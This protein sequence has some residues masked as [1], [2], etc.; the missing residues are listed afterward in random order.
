MT[1]RRS[2]E[3]RIERKK[4]SRQRIK[5]L[6]GRLRRIERKRAFLFNKI[7]RERVKL[8]KIKLEEERKKGIDYI[9]YVEP[10]IVCELTWR[11]TKR[12]GSMDIIT[13]KIRVDADP[14]TFNVMDWEAEKRREYGRNGGSAWGAHVLG[15]VTSDGKTWGVLK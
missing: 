2:A 8:E 4:L 12:N 7:F 9:D 13:R 3:R 10:F 11:T 14:L 5:A 1:E 15:Y 6:R